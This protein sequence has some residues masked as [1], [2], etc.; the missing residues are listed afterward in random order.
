MAIER[1]DYENEISLALSRT[2]LGGSSINTNIPFCYKKLDS[3]S[4]SWGNYI[5]FFNALLMLEELHLEKPTLS[6]GDIMFAKLASNNAGANPENEL[7]TSFLFPSNSTSRLIHPVPFVPFNSNLNEEQQCSIKMILGYNGGPS[8]TIFGP[9]KT[10]KTST[11]VEVISQVY[12]MNNY[13]RILVSYASNSATDHILEKL[14]S[15]DMAN[16]DENEILRLN[17]RSRSS[18]VIQLNLIRFCKSEC[19]TL[20]VLMRYQI[21]I[22]NCMNSSVFFNKGIQRGYFSLIFLDE[23]SQTSEP[24]CIIFLYSIFVKKKLSWF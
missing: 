1:N 19:P 3:P 21:I 18:Q 11:L 15:C 16:I 8:Y 20:Y 10:G 12:A 13:S 14:I 9:P 17:S 6:P 4:L 7:E 2:C 22:S 5:A 23:A 24:E